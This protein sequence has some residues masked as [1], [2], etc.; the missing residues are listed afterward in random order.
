MKNF[1]YL[2]I[3]RVFNV[4]F[5]VHP[6]KI[7]FMSYYG[8]QYGCNPKYISQYAGKYEQGWDIVWAL[9]QPNRHTIEEGRKVRYLSLRY[10]YDLCTCSVLVTNYRMNSWFK[11]RNSQFYVQTWHSSLRLKKIERDAEDTLPKGY[12]SMAKADSQNIDLLLSGC[13][14]STAIFE[15]CFWYSGKIFPSGT[16]RNDLL[17][18]QDELL[19]EKIFERLNL[20]KETALL[21]YAPTFRKGNRLD[22]YD[23][24]YDGLLEVLKS[25]RN[26]EWK[27][28]VRLHPHLRPYS[29]KLLGGRQVIDVTD[30]DDIQ[31][32]LYVADVLVSDYSSLVFDFAITH[33]P[34]F[35][36]TPDLE[37][38]TEN[39][40]QL[41]FNIED[42]PFPLC[43]TNSQLR[44]EIEAFNEEQYEKK[45]DTFFSGI[46][47]YETGNASANVMNC[48]KQKLAC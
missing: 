15:R 43:R 44:Q 16:P 35:L 47:S 40:R 42:L 1:L 45:I 26:C 25:Y 23:V 12:V 31:E 7:L 28:L 5:P 41:Y 17:F 4:L 21:L 29:E 8:E 39:D 37:S 2:L 22:C 33:K 48:I 6:K 9:C 46:G 18:R 20:S 11:K 3:I 32:L 13:E 36:Y 19:K 14:Y 34:C 10:F 24:D 38:Y 27:I 30:Y